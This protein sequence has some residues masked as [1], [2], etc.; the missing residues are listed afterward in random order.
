MSELLTKA[1]FWEKY[2][3]NKIEDMILPDRIRNIV[4]NGVN[5]NYLFHGASGMGKTTL[6]RILMNDYPDGQHLVLN[7]KIGE[8]KR[9]C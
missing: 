7:G 8:D 4:K 3:P 5:G 9:C 2:R 1:L 6:A